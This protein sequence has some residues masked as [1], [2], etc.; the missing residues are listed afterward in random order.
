MFSGH[1]ADSLQVF[2]SF[3]ASSSPPKQTQGG[4]LPPIPVVTPWDR[5]G[6]PPD[7]NMG[8]IAPIPPEGR[9]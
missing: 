4:A 7:V 1:A 3:P 6:T 5:A 2:S 8:A 9:T